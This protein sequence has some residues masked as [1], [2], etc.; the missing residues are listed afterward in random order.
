M[1]SICKLQ[2]ILFPNTTDQW[3]NARK[4]CSR[5][6]WPLFS[7]CECCRRIYWLLAF[8][9]HHLKPWTKQ[10]KSFEIL[11]KTRS[12]AFELMN[13]RKSVSQSI[14]P[15]CIPAKLRN[16]SPRKWFQL[17]D[18]IQLRLPTN[19]VCHADRVLDNSVMWSHLLV[20]WESLH[21]LVFRILN[22]NHPPNY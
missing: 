9:L 1:E 10:K 13:K 7:D 15:D 16:H 11:T 20:Y 5:W 2:K 3:R 12:C 4:P 22:E 8:R 19:I 14:H 6:M 18:R 17:S 21:N